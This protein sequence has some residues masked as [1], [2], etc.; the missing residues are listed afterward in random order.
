M[1]LKPDGNWKVVSEKSLPM[2]T[3]RPRAMAREKSNIK[4]DTVTIG[5]LP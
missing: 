3:F 2:A 4:K 5:R 1:N